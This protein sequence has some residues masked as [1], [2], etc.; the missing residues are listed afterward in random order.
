MRWLRTVVCLFPLL[1]FL[2]CQSRS[3]SFPA[4]PVDVLSS[5]EAI[6]DGEQVFLKQCAICHGARGHGDGPQAVNLKPPPSDLGN[7]Q[8]VR[9]EPGYWFF[10]IRE[11]GKEEPLARPGSAMPSWGDHLSDQEIWDVVAYLKSLVG[12]AA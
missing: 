12:E 3:V 9:S 7:L 5:P 6:R 8:G 1:L 4:P 2:G 11:G 10:R